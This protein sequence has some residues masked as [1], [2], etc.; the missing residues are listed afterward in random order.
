MIHGLASKP[1]ESDLHQL[2]SKSLIESLRVKDSPLAEALEAQSDSV[3]RH[4]YWANTTP[5][6]IEDAPS[7]VKKL[8]VQ[9]DK[10]IAERKKKKEA[11]HV[12]FGDKVGA[13]F[14]NRGLDV[15]KWMTGALTIKDDVAKRYLR[16]TEL[17]DEDQYVA[18][19][20]RRPLEEALRE[21]WSD[22]KD[23]TLISHSMGTFISYDV[24]WRFS[25]RNVKGFKEFRNK[26]VQMFV[27][28]GSPLGD[29][30]IRGFLFSRHH[31]LAKRPY[32]TNVQLWH[33][34]SC[35]GDVVSHPSKLDD[36]FF[37]DMKSAGIFSKKS[38]LKHQCIDYD[39]LYNPFTVVSH[40]D[41][42]GKEKRN[43]H[44]S[45]GYLVQPRLASWTADFLRGRI[46]LS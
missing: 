26:K 15:V 42:K 2:W 10:V 13:F 32:P 25:H 21:A 3:L 11:F 33:N 9:V 1:S 18:D 28:M 34:Y 16:E 19:R 45:Y 43:P 12:G 39:N 27:T 6:H 7:Y 40:K 4:A 41:N 8:A 5:H 22:G 20:M 14:K 17:Y 29:S 38:N 30:A 46:K 37:K 23:V 36:A 31:K 44:K 35:L 24:L